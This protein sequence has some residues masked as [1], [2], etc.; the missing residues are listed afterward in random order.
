MEKKS[1]DINSKFKIASTFTLSNDDVSVLSLLYAP[2]IGS[3]SLM[4]YLGFQSL[5]ERNNLSSEVLIHQDLFEI[6]SIT[7]KEF[8]L[9]RYKLEAIGL[10]TTFI[11][12][13]GNYTYFL[14]APLSAKNFIKDATL[15]LY[16]YS[17]VRRETFDFIYNHFKVEAI[18]KTNLTNITKTFDEVFT[19]QV[20]NEFAYDKFK[21]ILGKNTSKFKINNTKFDTDKFLHEI[22]KD[23]LETGVT[24]TFIDQINTLAYV[25]SFDELEMVNLYHDSLNRSQIFDYRLLK[26]KANI[27]FKYKRNMDAPKMITTVDA[28]KLVYDEDL[29]SYLET[30]SPKDFLEDLCPNF[31]D[32]YM[33]TVLQVYSNI[34]LPRGVLNAMIVKVVKQNSGNMPAFLYFKKVSQTWIKDGIFTTDDAVKYVTEYI[35]DEKVENKVKEEEVFESL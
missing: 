1:L 24:K 30:V 9:A 3:D 28:S 8:V 5:L 11:D 13:E 7:A 16:L 15:G 2:L 6:Y 10:G 18:N 27:Y 31:P 12:E 14:S 20:S 17:N 22:N 26:K 19:S 21:Y 29:I 23:F 4:I 25:Y 34:D 33:D 35:E 32:T